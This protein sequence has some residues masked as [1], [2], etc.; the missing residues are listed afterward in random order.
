MS[1]RLHPQPLDPPE[2]R[3]TTHRT[4]PH[5]MQARRPCPHST[6]YT[7]MRVPEST[8]DHNCLDLRRLCVEKLACSFSS[9]PLTSANLLPSRL[10]RSIDVD[11]A[12]IF[13]LHRPTD[14]RLQLAKPVTQQAMSIRFDDTGDSGVS[15]PNP[16]GSLNGDTGLRNAKCGAGRMGQSTIVALAYVGSAVE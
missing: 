4:G 3:R 15:H 2:E 1:I 6:P 9:A 16:V 14:P 8:T 5:R 12:F 11:V 13:H 7:S 10:A